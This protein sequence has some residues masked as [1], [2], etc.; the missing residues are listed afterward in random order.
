[1]EQNNSNK[2]LL[3]VVGVIALIVV[4][5]GSTFA[6]YTWTSTAT[7]DDTTINFTASGLTDCITY[8]YTAPST[9]TLTPVS[10][11]TS[12]TVATISVSSACPQTTVYVTFQMTPTTLDAGLKH[13]SVK[14]ELMQGATSLATGSFTGLT[15]GTATTLGTAQAITTG[16]AAKTYTLYL[17]IDGSVTNPSSL[18]SQ[19]YAMSIVANAT[20]QPS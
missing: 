18:Y 5:A 9:T 7:T 11:K 12:G 15:Q 17:W 10:A 1:M 13:S 19:N 4:V 3:M 16:A 6:W 20:D 14:Y 2:F 8:N